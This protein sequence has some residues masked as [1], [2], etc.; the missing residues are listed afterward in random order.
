MSFIRAEHKR[1]VLISATPDPRKER[2]C[3]GIVKNLFPALIKEMECEN[4]IGGAK[5]VRKSSV[6]S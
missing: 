6:T 3:G 5:S 1:A 2:F 4:L